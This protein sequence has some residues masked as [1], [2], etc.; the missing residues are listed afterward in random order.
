MGVKKYVIE[1]IIAEQ[2]EN[3]N[4]DSIFLKKAY[5]MCNGQKDALNTLEKLYNDAKEVIKT[6]LEKRVIDNTNII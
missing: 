6:K 2:I 3:E 1:I 4:M 5:E